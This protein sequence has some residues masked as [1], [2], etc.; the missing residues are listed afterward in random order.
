VRRHVII[1]IRAQ[2]KLPYPVKNMLPMLAEEK[3]KTEDGLALF[4]ISRFTR[5]RKDRI[6]SFFGDETCVHRG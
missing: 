6:S 5:L 2:S 1:V 4:T 3:L